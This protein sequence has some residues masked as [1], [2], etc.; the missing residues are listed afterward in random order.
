[1]DLP[2]PHVQ[3]YLLHKCKCGRHF[4]HNLYY[5][6]YILSLLTLISNISNFLTANN[7]MMILHRSF[8]SI[9]HI[10]RINSITKLV[11]EAIW[12]CTG[13]KS[14]PKAILLVAVQGLQGEIG[15]MSLM[16]CHKCFLWDGRVSPLQKR[17]GSHY[18]N[19]CVCVCVRELACNETPTCPG[20]E[21]WLSILFPTVSVPQINISQN[22]HVIIY[23]EN[24][25]FGASSWQ[26]EEAEGT[27]QKQL[28]TPTTPMT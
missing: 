2:Y 1:M 20:F 19:M 9:L 3:I 15:L 17:I 13:L 18:I 6:R 4:C 23:I 8:R 5:K 12:E 26:R 28:P 14:T 21:L 16:P 7:S 24:E 25:I 22:F 11:W 27:P 10:I